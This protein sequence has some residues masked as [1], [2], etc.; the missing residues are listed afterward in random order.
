MINW[1]S[2]KEVDLAT[3]MLAQLSAWSSRLH[4]SQNMCALLPK[5]ENSSHVLSIFKLCK[6]ITVHE[7]LFVSV[8]SLIS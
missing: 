8:F 4:C 3:S 2:T 5:L 1:L 7:V 6:Y